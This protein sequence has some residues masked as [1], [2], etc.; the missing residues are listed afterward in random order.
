MATHS[1]IEVARRAGVSLGTVSNVL[2]RPHIVA[3][4]TRRRVQ[5]AIEELGFVRNEAARRLRAGRSNTI[6]LLVLD[7]ANPFFTDVAHGVESLADEHGSTVMLCNS[8][9]NAARERR[10]LDQ[11]EEL[12]VLGV[13]ITPVEGISPRLEQLIDRGTPVVLVDRDNGL[14]TCAVAVDNVLG[15]RLATNHLIEQGHRRLAFVGG[16]LSLQQVSDRHAGGAGRPGQRR[17]H[18]F[19]RG[20]QRARR[21]ARHRAPG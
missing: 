13:L 8:G 21:A 9:D 17:E 14:D 11:L 19:G 4:A 5:S 3:P 16:P 20:R 2:N 12:R 15:G 6:G 10:Y 1:I 7:V 18:V